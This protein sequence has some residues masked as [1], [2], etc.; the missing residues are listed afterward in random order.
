MKKAIDEF[1]QDKHS[2]ISCIAICATIWFLVVCI[3][4]GVY[5]YC[6]FNSASS[7]SQDIDG[8]YNLQKVVR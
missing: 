6:S 1:R 8:N 7:I 2:F 3:L 4:F 5:I